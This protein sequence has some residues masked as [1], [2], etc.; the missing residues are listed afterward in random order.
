LRSLALF[1]RQGWGF[2]N[3]TVSNDLIESAFDALSTIAR[4]QRITSQAVSKRH[5]RNSPHVI[6]RNNASSFEG[7]QR[8]R[9]PRNRDLSTMAVYPQPGAQ[10]SDLAQKLARKHHLA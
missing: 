2:T 9:R 6:F 4:V 10:L 1:H 7:T 5:A 3:A 8:T